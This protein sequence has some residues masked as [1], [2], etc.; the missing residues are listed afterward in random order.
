MQKLFYFILIILFS[1]CIQHSIIT[2]TKIK[3]SVVLQSQRD[4]FPFH[5][6]SILTNDIDLETLKFLNGG[7]D[8]GSLSIFLTK[9]NTYVEA[10]SNYLTRDSIGFTGIM[11]YNGK[12]DTLNLSL[13]HI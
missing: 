6:N 2:S 9:D 13:I 10:R 4:T 7:K 11:L 3:G 8:Q 12:N 1:G 5:S